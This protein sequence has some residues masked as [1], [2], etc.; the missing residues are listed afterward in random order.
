MDMTIQV[1][2]G[3]TSQWAAST[4]ILKQGEIALD[5]TLNKIKFGDG[6]SL[7]SALPFAN[8]LPSELKELTQDY[9]G[10]AFA[11]GT[12]SHITVTYDDATN[13]FSFATAPEVVLSTGL[14]NTLGDYL[15]ASAFNAQLDSAGGTPTLDQDSYIRDIEISPR[16]ARI[17][18]PAFT[19]TVSGITKIM[20][21]LGNVDNTSDVNKPLSTANTAALALKAPI[22]SP[23]FTGTVSTGN[24]SVSGNL[25]ITGTT[26]T[27]STQNLSVTNPLIY[28]GSNNQAN[29]IDVGVVG[30]FNNGTYQHTGLARDHS[31]NKWK[32]FKGVT[33]EPSTTIN[34]SQSVLDDIAVGNLT[35]TTISSPTISSTTQLNAV[36]LTVTGTVILPDNAIKSS[37][38]DWEHYNTEADLPLATLKHGMFAHVHGTGSAYYAHSGGWYKLA[39]TSDVELISYGTAASGATYLITSANTSKVTELTNTTEITV[40][41]PSD[42]TDSIYPIGSTV[43]FRQMGDGRLKFVPTSPAT[44]VSTDSYIRTR[45]KYSSAVL[46]KRASNSW[47]L[48]GDIDA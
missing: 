22:A 27:Q 46:E 29:I 32:L 8:I 21:G 31:A 11:A 47:I 42:P 44:L 19:G 4:R 16:I 6:T 36:G 20:V 2:R 24:L 14:S 15:T 9:I 30:S 12:H 13:K 38:L 33:D 10:E 34:W 26:T 37:L 23:T 7:W 45:T 3:T 28:V 43:E 41:I 5:T 39:K 48:V 1:R 35:S 25:T 40:T 18:S 17:D